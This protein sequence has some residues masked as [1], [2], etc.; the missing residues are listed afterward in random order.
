MIV[1]CASLTETLV[2]GLLFGYERGAYTGADRSHEGLIRQADGGTLFLDEVGELS[3]SIQRSFL[4]VLEEHRFRPLG[5]KQEVQSNFR[6][7]A[8]TNRDLEQLVREG[9][10]RSDLLHRLRA[11]CIELPPLRERTDDIPEL[12]IYQLIKI[13]D[14]YGMKIKE[15]SPELLDVLLAYEWPGNVRELVHTLER[16]VAA[17]NNDLLLVPKHLPLNIRISMAR[18]SLAERTVGSNN[19]PPSVILPSWQDYR[20]EM[21]AGV[22]REYLRQLMSLAG[23]NVKKA[24][25][26]S[27]LCRSRLYQFLKKHR[28]PL[29]VSDLARQLE[30]QLRQVELLLAGLVAGLHDAR[31]R[32]RIDPGG[33]N[34]L[35][36]CRGIGLLVRC[37]LD[38]GGNRL[39]I[40]RLAI[41]AALVGVAVGRRRTVLA[42][43]LGIE[44][45]VGNLGGIRFDLGRRFDF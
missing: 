2:E 30:G 17:A 4:R 9:Q 15:I 34:R 28:F 8:A 22:E 40:D 6:L 27:G 39:G 37:C 25:E 5:S 44:L 42:D 35:A 33:R 18:R 10:F 26:M 12:A 21:M 24:C 19:R 36:R 38:R 14:R 23:N 32:H 41:V 13:C 3:Y 31:R 20:E 43:G 29:A 16:M 11:F 1:D 7:V 45:G